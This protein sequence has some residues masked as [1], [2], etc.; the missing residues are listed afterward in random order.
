MVMHPSRRNLEGFASLHPDGRP[1]R[2]SPPLRR[3]RLRHW[4]LTNE[5]PH[6]PGD[7]GQPLALV[8]TAPL[9]GATGPGAAGKVVRLM[10]RCNRARHAQP[11][12]LSCLCRTLALDGRLRLGRKPPRVSERSASG[13]V[14]MADGRAERF[15]V[16]RARPKLEVATSRIMD[17]LDSKSANP[18]RRSLMHQRPVPKR[19]QFDI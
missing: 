7:F 19:R 3:W 13:V 14:T 12:K 4:R 9:F 8:D 11:G 18:S 10:W 15:A 6:G 16:L 5:S 1:S 2:L 17:N